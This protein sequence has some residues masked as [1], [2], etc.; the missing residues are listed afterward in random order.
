[1]G[2]GEAQ[3]NGGAPGRA[4]RGALARDRPRLR[5]ADGAR[6]APVPDRAAARR[7]DR[8]RRGGRAAVVYYTALLVNVGCHSDAHEQAKWFGDDIALKSG[9]VR[10]RVPAAARGRGGGP[11][12]RRR[13]PAAP[14][15]PRRAR[16]R[17]LG[18]PRLRR[19]D[20]AARGH[21]PGRSREQLGLSEAVLEA[22]G[23]AYEQWDGRGWP[24]T[25]SGDRASR[26][27]RGLAQLARVRRGRPPGRRR[28]GR[29]GDS[30]AQRAGK[31]FDPVLAATRPSTRAS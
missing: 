11:A 1:M 14:P 6:P 3:P 27:G 31:Q 9:E 24:G 16:V 2:T 21:G 23:A 22:L 8:A 19:D 29:E 26:R 17:P 30:R 4:R 5:A 10:L 25:L 18:P 7:A 12:D 20:R 28:R 13:Q 15:L